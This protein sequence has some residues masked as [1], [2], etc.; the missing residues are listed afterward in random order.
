MTDLLRRAI[1]L[2]CPPD[3][4]FRVF[5]DRVELWWPRGHRH[6][7]DGALRFDG[8]RLIDR[9]PDGTEWTMA[10]V[11]ERAE[12]SRLRLAWF[13]GSPN[14][15]TDVEIAFAPEGAGT[16]VTIV[17]RPLAPAAA[18]VWAARVATFRAGWEAVA[19]ALAEFIAA[20]R[21]TF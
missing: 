1:P 16:L 2:A 17:H 10:S 4:A 12:P 5:V 3:H 7:R 19:M 20:E 8:D 11:I 6:F 13:P 21:G 14:A 9:A 15:P 18:E